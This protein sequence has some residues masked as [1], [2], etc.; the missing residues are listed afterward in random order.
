MIEF[1]AGEDQ[2]RKPRLDQFL[3]ERLTSLSLTRIRTLI[4]VGEIVV[5]GAPSLKGV[6][7]Q[8]GD[9]V[10]I[11]D[12]EAGQAPTSA[13]PE[14]ISLVILYEDEEIIV[15]NKPSGMLTHPSNREKSGALT[16]ALA[17]HFLETTG[18]PI[19]AGLIH[20]LDRDTSGA[21]VVAKTLRAHRALSNAFRDRRVSKTYLAIVSGVPALESGEID[22]PIGSDP[23]DWPH[24]K[25]MEDGRPAKTRYEVRRRF[26]KHAMLHLEPLTGRTHQIRIHC[27]LI[28]HPLFGDPVYGIRN[29]PEAKQFGVKRHILHAQR[30]AFPHPT[31]REQ[32]D[33]IAPLPQPIL[34]LIGRLTADP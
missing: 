9:V 6:R 2:I 15:V 17:H 32:I 10:V 14:Q 21:I 24:W 11:K 23:T 5:N 16:N 28:G 4:A 12:N 29:D 31:R 19:R 8:P 13:T 7:L 26:P 30:L 33:L 18:R 22:A 20:R 25:V 3:A 27:A 34:D 1:T